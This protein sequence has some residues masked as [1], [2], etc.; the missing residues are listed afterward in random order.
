MIEFLILQD[1]RGYTANSLLPGAGRKIDVELLKEHL[2]QEGMVVEI[3]NLHELVFPTKYRGWYV[4][5]PSSEDPGLFYKDY[6]EDILLRLLMD[7]A[8]LLPSFE[9]FRAHH[10]K[11][12][13][14]SFRSVLSK[15]YNSIK[16]FS[17]YG[18]DDLEKKLKKEQRYPVIL[19]TSAGAG[20]SG[21]AIAHNQQEALKIAKKMERIVFVDYNSS[22]IAQIRH[23]VG[24]FI[25]KVT[26]QQVVEIPK[27]QT[28]MIC[29]TYVPNLTCD[30]KVLVFG[31]KY[32]LLRRQVKKGDF[33]A[34]G[35][36][37]REFPNELG[38]EE[39][40]V[41]NFA[42]G[43]YEQLKSPLLSIDIAYDGEKCHM[44]EFQCLNFGPYTL[45]CSKWYYRCVDTRWE[46][47]KKASILEEEMA[48]AYVD[49]VR[50]RGK[51]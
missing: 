9:L 2:I 25:R 23:A 17:F 43:A 22:I 10:N 42:K 31:D 21:V 5:Y 40:H 11:V 15:E 24:K 8:I 29:Q 46:Q 13:M 3:R 14:E 39:I 38:T 16:S 4:V 32:Y 35:S 12:F 48:R 49:Y 20:S 7:G 45:Q 26:K 30:Y 34:S 27:I 51:S 33:R 28:K 41:L 1:K 36:G 44:I 37:L 47:I 18:V 6:I 50:L 19:K